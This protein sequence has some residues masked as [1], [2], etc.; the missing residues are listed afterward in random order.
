MNRST[1]ILNELKEISPLV[2]GIGRENI[3]SVP[4]GYFDTVAGTALASVRNEVF[5]GND[6][7]AGYFDTLS[8]NIL[9][10]IDGT[11][12]NELQQVSPMLASIKKTNPYEVPGNYFEQVGAEISTLIEEQKVPALLMGLNNKQTYTVPDGYFEQVAGDILTRVTWKPG[13]K[14][15]TMAKRRNAILKYAAAA[16]FTGAVALGIY[17]YTNTTTVP[18]VVADATVPMD[19]SRFTETLNNLS[20]DDIIKYLEKNGS[21]ADVAALTS[22]IDEGSLPQREE[23]LTDDAALDNFLGDIEVKN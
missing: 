13:A 7:P 23:Y 8:N 19:P 16:V 2:A 21:E 18:P 9:S 6:V 1:D 20:E 14:V 17:Q 22:G 5:T 4:R 15:I 12:A 10:K 11:V 3:F